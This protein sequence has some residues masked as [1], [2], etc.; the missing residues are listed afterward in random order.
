M[1]VVHC[2]IIPFIYIDMETR[3]LYISSFDVFI[4]LMQTVDVFQAW[5]MYVRWARQY[6]N[7]SFDMTTL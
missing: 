4:L 5:Y 2:N 6:I 7:I 1:Y 3:M